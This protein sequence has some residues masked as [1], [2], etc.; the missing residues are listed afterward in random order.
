MCVRLPSL[1]IRN[2]GVVVAFTV[3]DLLWGPL[4][5]LIFINSI[6]FLYIF[7]FIVY[8]LLMLNELLLFLLYWSVYGNMI[9]VCSLTFVCSLGILF[10]IYIFE[11]CILH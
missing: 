9:Y 1:V 8:V 6:C 11:Y 4:P 10:Y 3:E 2:R 7:P 5:A